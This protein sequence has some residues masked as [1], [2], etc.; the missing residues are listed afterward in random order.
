MVGPLIGGFLA[1]PAEK[2]P[3]AF[4]TAKLF[5]KFPYLLPNMVVA[6]PFTLGFV[7]S[8]FYLRV[9]IHGPRQLNPITKWLGIG[10]IRREES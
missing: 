2:Y 6:V 7:G 5:V 3:K 8:C 9:S 10:D 1:T 4:G